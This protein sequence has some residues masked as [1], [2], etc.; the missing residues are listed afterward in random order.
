MTVEFLFYLNSFSFL[1]FLVLIYLIISKSKKHKSLRYLA[2]L[3]FTTLPSFLNNAMILNESIFKF[4][5]IF[6]FVLFSASIFGLFF[7][8]HVDVLLRGTWNE[9]HPI[10]VISYVF[11][12]FLFCFCFHFFAKTEAEQTEF[13]KRVIT[14]DFPLL[15]TIS[16]A[17]FYLIQLLYFINTGILIFKEKEKQKELPYVNLFSQRINYLKRFWTV[18][19]LLYV[20]VIGSYAF[21]SQFHVEFFILPIAMNVVYLYIFI[22]VDHY[23]NHYIF[24]TTE[25]TSKVKIEKETKSNEEQ[26]ETNKELLFIGD[27]I[28]SLLEKDKLFLKGD[29]T[30]NQLAEHLDIPPYKVSHLIK[31]NFQVNFPDLINS[32]R[33]QHAKV[34]LKKIDIDKESIEGIAYQSGFNS[35][36]SFYRA[37]K[38]YTSGTPSQYLNSKASN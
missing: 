8:A 16:N 13:L 17:I 22:N 32:Y 38:R 11:F 30:A 18:I 9:F 33:I 27:Q 5:I 10:N 20:S 31:L 14:G 35:K 12:L 34:L 21:F 4:P 3:A 19:I 1:Y 2:F 7:K 25:G 29:L 24:S 36:A 23:S 26:V 37:F 15:F 6:F 28:K